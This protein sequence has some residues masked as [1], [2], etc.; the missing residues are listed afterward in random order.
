MYVDGNYVDFHQFGLFKR[1][2]VKKD[3]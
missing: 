2:W 3:I 1:D